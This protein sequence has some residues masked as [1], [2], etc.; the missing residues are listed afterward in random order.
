M[1]TCPFLLKL[2][3]GRIWVLYPYYLLTRLIIY[4]KMQV[5]DFRKDRDTW[6]AAIAG[7]QPASAFLRWF[8]MH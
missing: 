4:I 1:E 5:T 6:C 8:L 3:T 7:M 2:C